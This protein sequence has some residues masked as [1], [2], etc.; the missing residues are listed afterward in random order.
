MDF[1]NNIPFI[2]WMIG[3][4]RVRAKDLPRDDE[5]KIIVDLSQPHILEDMDYFRPTALHFQRTGRMTDL[6]PN[7]NPTSEYGKWVREEIRRCH[8]GYI[9]QSDG[10]WVTGDMYWFLNYWPI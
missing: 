2:K 6:R 7:A 8:E 3:A 10:E 5:G 9:R 1:I 4:N